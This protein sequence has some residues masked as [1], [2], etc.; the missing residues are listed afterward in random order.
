MPG[1]AFYTTDEGQTW[2]ADVLYRATPFDHEGK[3]AYGAIVVE[4]DG[5]PYV[6]LLTRLSDAFLYEA[7]ALEAGIRFNLT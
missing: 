4:C 7:R 1:R 6:A 5:K 2:F 3:P